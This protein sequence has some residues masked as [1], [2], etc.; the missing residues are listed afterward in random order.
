[1]RSLDL[2]YWV[3]A[4]TMLLVAVFF[5]LVRMDGQLYLVEENQ[6]ME[7]IQLSLIIIAGALFWRNSGLNIVKKYDGTQDP[8]KR[9]ALIAAILCFSFLVRELSVKNSGIEWLIYIVDGTGYKLLMLALWLPA[10]YS[11]AQ[12]WQ[13]YWQ[14]LKASLFSATAKFTM[15]AAMLLLAGALFD[16]EIIVVEYFR[17]YEEV[18][19]MAAYGMLILAAMSFSKDMAALNFFT[20]ATKPAETSLA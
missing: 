2:R 19:E 17:F 15:L 10:L 5:Y 7:H 8:I 20:Q 11:L 16:K 1:M 13:L 9:I 12:Q 4:V 3:G 14:L 18:L 6:W